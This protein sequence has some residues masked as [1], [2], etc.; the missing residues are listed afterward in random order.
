ML[1]LKKVSKT[2]T[3]GKTTV[4]ALQAVDFSLNRGDFVVIRGPSGADK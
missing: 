4:T 3:I 2:Y 1:E